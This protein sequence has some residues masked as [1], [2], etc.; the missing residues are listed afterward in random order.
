MSCDINLAEGT[1]QAGVGTVISSSGS[2]D[3]GGTVIGKE[4]AGSNLYNAY[5]GP[6][7]RF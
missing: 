1:G 7:T 3:H 6:G 4:A 5:Y 2:R